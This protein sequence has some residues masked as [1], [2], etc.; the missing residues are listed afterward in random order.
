M[1]ETEQN[2]SPHMEM[3]DPTA[4][5]SS[6]LE[7]LPQ[8]ALSQ[9]VDLCADSLSQ[10]R[11]MAGASEGLRETIYQQQWKCHKCHCSIFVASDL[12]TDKH[13][14]PFVCGVCH[15]KFCG[16][17]VD[18][19]RRHCRPQRCEGCGKVECYDCQQQHLQAA[20]GYGTENY[21]QDC[22]AEF[23]FGMGGC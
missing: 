7:A 1:S 15:R 2:H 23:D 4:A 21:C 19:D 10:I 20:D 13:A 9:V 6:L 16:E 8:D 17:S 12:T 3:E 18:Y 5:T 22:Q 14:K 11:N